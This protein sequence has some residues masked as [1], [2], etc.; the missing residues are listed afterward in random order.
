M[1]KLNDLFNSKA[2]KAVESA[3]LV[4]VA[5]FLISY[6][7]LPTDL[8]S[9]IVVALAGVVGVDGISTAISAFDTHNKNEVAKIN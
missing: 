5:Y 8:V 1:N 9:T 6:V 3:L 7:K 2:F 4:A